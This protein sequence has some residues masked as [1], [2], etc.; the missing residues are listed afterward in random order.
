MER[1][2]LLDISRVQ[3][4]T[5]GHSR[6]QGPKESRPSA[7]ALHSLLRQLRPRRDGSMEQNSSALVLIQEAQGTSRAG[8]V[9]V[10][11]EMLLPHNYHPP[12]PPD[13][14]APTTAPVLPTSSLCT[15]TACSCRPYICVAVSPHP[16][17]NPTGMSRGVRRDQ[18][19]R[20]LQG[21]RA[22]WHS[23]QAPQ[24]QNHSVNTFC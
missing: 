18:A 7:S 4:L 14:S 8:P 10:L 3:F 23:T 21:S 15:V 6:L 9:P 5:D 22:V 17:P 11:A 1:L 13:T 16:D 20:M 24:L 19:W 2:F 12:P